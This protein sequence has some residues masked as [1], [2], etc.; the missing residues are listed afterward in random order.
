M[1]VLLR[2]SGCEGCRGPAAYT[3]R[4]FL[5]WGG[6][7]HPTRSG[8]VCAALEFPTLQKDCTYYSD[9]AIYDPVAA[10][11]S[12]ITSKNAP[13]NMFQPSMLWTGKVALVWDRF[14]GGSGP[15][16]VYSYDPATD[17][18]EASSS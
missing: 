10:E 9:G 16:P 12:P 1:P 2:R 14:G 15:A 5:V 8:A 18:W 6:S 11:W 3:G 13:A 17:T 7:R 4:V